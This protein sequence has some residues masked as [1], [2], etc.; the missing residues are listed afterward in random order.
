VTA[1]LEDTNDATNKTTVDGS[2]TINVQLNNTPE[3]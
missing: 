1:E 3:P 2:T